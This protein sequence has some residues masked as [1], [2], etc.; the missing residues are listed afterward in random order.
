MCHGF[1]QIFSIYG[2][3]VH[4]KSGNKE[5]SRKCLRKLLKTLCHCDSDRELCSRKKQGN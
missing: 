5:P 3:F 1:W 4:E 2:P